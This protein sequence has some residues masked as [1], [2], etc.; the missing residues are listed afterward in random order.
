MTPQLELLWEDIERA[1][2]RMA[3]DRAG[4]SPH[5]MG[6]IVIAEIKT[7]DKQVRA[8]EVIDGQQRLTTFQLPLDGWFWREEDSRGRLVKSRLDWMLVDHLSMEK[9]DLVSADNCS[10]AIAAGS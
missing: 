6:A 9:A 3:A 10:K 1:L 8:Y 7:F 4:S 2:A 5:Y